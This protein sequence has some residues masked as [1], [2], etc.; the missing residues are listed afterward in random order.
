MTDI[1]DDDIDDCSIDPRVACSACEAVCCRL[2]VVVMPEDD[3]PRHFLS[4][5]PGGLTVMAHGDDGWCAALD[6]THM[7]CG[8]Y[9]RRPDVCR[10]FAMGGGY[11]RSVR[12]EFEAS[13]P[14]E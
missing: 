8:I 2:T 3:V 10:R 13:P 11:C 4:Q 12:A 6:R 14:L 7:R 9:E 5:E 1:T